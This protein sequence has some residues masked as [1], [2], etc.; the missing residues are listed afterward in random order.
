MTAPLIIPPTANPATA[1]AAPTVTGL[2]PT[3]GL[4][5]VRGIREVELPAALLVLDKPPKLLSACEGADGLEYGVVV[6]RRCLS[7]VPSLGFW[8][9]DL[10]LLDSLC[11]ALACLQRSF[12]CL[13]KCSV[14]RGFTTSSTANILGFPTSWT[15]GINGT[16]L[17]AILTRAYHASSI[18]SS[19]S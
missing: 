3:V 7:S 8:Y 1:P 16:G 4:G 11:S 19:R 17:V 15:G 14:C 6:G 13:V 18:Y 5:T 10:G 9:P 12:R 2:T